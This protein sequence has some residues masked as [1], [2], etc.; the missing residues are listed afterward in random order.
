[1]R[2]VAFV[3]KRAISAGALDRAGR[4]DAIAMAN[5]RHH[6]R[7]HAGAD[8][9]ARRRGASRWREDGVVRAQGVRATAEARKRPLKLAEAMVDAD[10]EVKGVIEKGKLLTL[11]TDEALKLKVADFAPTRWTRCSST[12]GLAGAECARHAAL[13][14]GAGAFPDP[15][16]GQLAADQAGMLGIITEMRTPGFGVPG[17]VGLASLAL[18]LWGHWLVQ[19]AGW[20]E[21][22]LAAAGLVLLAV[23][24]FVIPGFGVSA[25]ALGSSPSFGGL[26]LSMVGPA[27]PAVIVAVQYRGG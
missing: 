12:L 14:R 19:L 1:V 2:T 17:A 25:G 24:I 27:I 16:G 10:V 15:P 13:G 21:L 8:G 4:R 9:R 5:G 7:G 3:N 22:L 6:R 18:F 26:V 11:T 23:E 20:E